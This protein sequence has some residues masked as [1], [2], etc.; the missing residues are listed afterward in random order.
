MNHDL[1]LKKLLNLIIKEP[2]TDIDWT[3]KKRIFQSRIP[4]ALLPEEM[5]N[6]ETPFLTLT[7]DE[8]IQFDES[9]K[10]LRR[11][12]KTEYLKDREIKDRLWYLICEVWTEKEDF[13]NTQKLKNKIKSFTEDICKPL[14]FYEVLFKVHNLKIKKRIK[15]LDCFIFT[16]TK[17]GLVKRGFKHK[18]NFFSEI[19]K[20]FENQTLLSI[21]EKGNKPSLVADR[22]KER[23]NYI[24]KLL[25]TYLSRIEYVSDEFLLFSL[26]EDYLIKKEN[27]SVIESYG[28]R[29]SFKPM[30]FDYEKEFRKRIAK[31]NK[32][33]KLIERVPEKLK[34]VV[35]R[36]IFWIGKSISE[37][38]FDLKVAYLCISLETLL[39][40]KQDG[41]KGERI[42]YRTALLKSH[43]EKHIIHPRHILWLYEIR[44]SIV[45]GSQIGIASKAEYDSLLRLTKEMLDYFIRL[46]QKNSLNKQTDLIKFLSESKYTEKLLNWLKLFPDKHSLEIAKVLEEDI[47]E[48]VDYASVPICSL[49]KK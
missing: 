45:H 27:E 30:D 42:A 13:K 39:T 14:E 7:D 6:S 28:G 35:E 1:H 38:D 36:A 34:K 41:R 12:I 20:N 17:K 37:I 4:S 49:I 5:T 22:A 11:D 24:V 26:S 44:S 25:Q 33:S 3:V 48:K 16:Y 46:I 43:F 32:H 18:M 8:A 23:G 21:I 47:S 10:E 2:Q 40:T 29:R 9:I 19:V 15:V 31:A